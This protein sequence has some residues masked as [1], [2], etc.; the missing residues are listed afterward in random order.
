MCAS[1]LLKNHLLIDCLSKL[2]PSPVQCLSLKKIPPICSIK[3]AQLDQNCG[4]K[5]ACW[6]VTNIPAMVALVNVLKAPANS[7]LN[8][9]LLTSP[10]RPGAI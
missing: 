2:D 6:S 10:V 8:A 7:A 9:S 5:Y 4:L 1:I 3:A